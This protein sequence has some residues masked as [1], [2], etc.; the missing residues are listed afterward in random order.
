MRVIELVR[1][2]MSRI[3]CSLKPEDY[4]RRGISTDGPLTLEGLL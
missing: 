2:Q 4:E 1:G 3:L